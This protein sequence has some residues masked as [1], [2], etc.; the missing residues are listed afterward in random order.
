VQEG[1][2]FSIPSPAFVI[3][4]LINDGHS[5]WCEVVSHGSF[6]LHF[7]NNQGCWAFFSCACWPSGLVLLL[8]FVFL[9]PHPW[10]MEVPRL[11]VELELEPLTYTI[12][13]AIW[14]LSCV[15]NLYHSSWQHRILNPPS[16]PRIKPMSSWMP[17]RFSNLWAT[18][19]TPHYIVYIQV[20][21]C[22]W[23]LNRRQEFP[24]RSVGWGAGVVTAVVRVGSL[25]PEIFAPHRQGQK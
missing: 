1:S 10:H 9:G 13:T 24:G 3:C 22:V 25:S 16:K 15:C 21:F 2:L 18:I 7:S 4:G 6:D 19:W 17:I 14:D 5:D 11:G 20:H 8:A 12:A 23:P